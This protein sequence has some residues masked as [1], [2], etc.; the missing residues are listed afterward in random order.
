[1]EE[2]FQTQ[3]EFY[4]PIL[5]NVKCAIFDSSASLQGLIEMK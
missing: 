4:K 2:E 3:V 5:G 1:M